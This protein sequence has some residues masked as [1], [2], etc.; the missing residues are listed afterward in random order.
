METTTTVTPIVY[1]NILLC[2]L[3]DT[4]AERYMITVYERQLR[5][6]RIPLRLEHVSN[7]CSAHRIRLESHF[8]WR[9]DYPFTANVW[10]LFSYRYWQF[11]RRFVFRE[12]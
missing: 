11:R 2:L 5:E 7:W 8:I 10:N 4:D 12:V 1:H 9:R 3:A 6:G